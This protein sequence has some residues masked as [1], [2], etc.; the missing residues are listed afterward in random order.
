M[1]HCPMAMNRESIQSAIDEIDLI[2]RY[3]ENFHRG[4]LLAAVS[5]AAAA[6]EGFPEILQ[7]GSE[8]TAKYLRLIAEHSDRFSD[9]EIFDGLLDGR[10]ALRRGRDFPA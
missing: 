9:G 6:L 8:A 5:Q 7:D 3:L 1:Y 2:E 10:R 4:E